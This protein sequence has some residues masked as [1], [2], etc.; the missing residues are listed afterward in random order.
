MPGKGEPH[1]GRMLKAPAALV[2]SI[3][4]RRVLHASWKL[5]T[6]TEPPAAPGDKR[7]PLGQAVAW[8]ALFGGAVA[9]S[10]MMASRYASSLWL[11]RAQRR[12]LPEPGQA[13]GH[14]QPLAEPGAPSLASLMAVAAL[15]WRRRR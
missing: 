6:G 2:A 3:A 5:L 15:A 1:S 9:T 12:G 7:V 13:D 11:S 4:V 8:A 14:G 10:R